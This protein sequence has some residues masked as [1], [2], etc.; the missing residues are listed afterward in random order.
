MKTLIIHPDD[1]STDFLKP[2]YEKIEDKTVITKGLSKSVVHELIDVH[3]RI[4]MMGH[5]NP[6]GLFSMGLFPD[7]RGLIIDQYSVVHLQN[8]DCIYIW[9][10]ADQFVRHFGLNG[11]YSGMFVSEVGEA[12][13]CDIICPPNI[14]DLV[15]E[16]NDGFAKILG[17]YVNNPV[18]VIHE[19]VTRL[20]QTLADSNPV[21]SYNNKRLYL[22]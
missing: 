21:A 13:D 7:S 3:D 22:S 14:E 18:S 16:S 2:I 20:Y 1:R 5:G 6:Y 15:N 19:Q 11:F 12:Y 4:I 9:C 8:K 17:D 10:N